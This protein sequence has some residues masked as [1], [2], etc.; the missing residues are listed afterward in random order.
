MQNIH[1]KNREKLKPILH[2]MDQNQIVSD[3]QFLYPFYDELKAH[4]DRF[5]DTNTMERF[6]TGVCN[7]PLLVS[8]STNRSGFKT[9]SYYQ[10]HFTRDQ[11]IFLQQLLGFMDRRRGVKRNTGYRLYI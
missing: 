6:F 7:N 2:T 3:A 5:Y 8:Y 11:S 4:I 10:A 9:L 1:F